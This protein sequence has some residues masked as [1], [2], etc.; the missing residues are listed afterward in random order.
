MGRGQDRSQRTRR[1]GNWSELILEEEEE[2]VMRDIEP[3]LFTANPDS[4]S[5]AE[6]QR[7]SSLGRRGL[8]LWTGEVTR[9]SAG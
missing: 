3:G 4:A 1:S 8:R 6:G 2:G 7:A 5:G 9:G